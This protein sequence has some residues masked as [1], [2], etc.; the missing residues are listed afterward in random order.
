MN[1][2]IHDNDYAE[3]RVLEYCYDNTHN[4]DCSKLKTVDG[5]EHLFTFSFVH[6]IYSGEFNHYV[7]ERVVRVTSPTFKGG[8]QYDVPLID[9]TL[10][11]EHDIDIVLRTL[12]LNG[13]VVP[14]EIYEKLYNAYAIYI[15]PYM[16][17]ED[18]SKTKR[19]P[20]KVLLSKCF[21]SRV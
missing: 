14:N 20:W 17:N 21:P 5:V 13:V 7:R 8:F 16:H 11:N 19:N 2:K 10:I 15:N 9:T 12:M 1:E 18:L 3:N 4:V 6:A